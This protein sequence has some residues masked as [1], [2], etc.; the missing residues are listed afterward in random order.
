[1]S[2]TRELGVDLEDYTRWWEMVNEEQGST[3][4]W[5]M[6]KEDIENDLKK[7]N[8]H[9]PPSKHDKNKTCKKG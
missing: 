2:D 9:E 3:E 1:M 7:M 6:V 8:L 4:W 5:N